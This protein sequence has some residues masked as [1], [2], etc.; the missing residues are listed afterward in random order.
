MRVSEVAP[1]SDAANRLS[2]LEGLRRL[3]LELEAPDG[4][5]LRFPLLMTAAR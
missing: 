5:V 3:L 2:G 4:T 1:G